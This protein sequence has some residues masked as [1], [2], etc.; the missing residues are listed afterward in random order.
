MKR[1]MR[2]SGVDWIGEIPQD[3]AVKKLSYLFAEIGSGTTPSSTNPAFYDGDI[4]WV[5]TGDLND[6]LLFE[7]SKKIT[8]D[9][10]SE[11]STLKIY[12]ENALIIAMYGATIGKTAITKMKCTVN[13]ACC[14]LAKAINVDIRYVHFWFLQNKNNIIS[15]SYGGGQPNISQD[16]IRTLKIQVPPFEE[17]KTIADYLDKKCAEI[18]AVINSKQEQNKLLKEQ[19]QSIIYE[20]VTK[21]LDKNAPMKDSGVEWIGEIPQ[22]WSVRRLK[23]CVS[24][25][26]EKVL[27]E[28]NQE[29]LLYLGLEHIEQQTGKIEKNYLPIYDFEGDTIKFKSGDVL[30]GKLRPYLAKCYLAQD[31]GKCSS[32]FL[33]LTPNDCFENKYVAYGMLSKGF[34]D[35]VDSSTFGVKM[36]RADWEFISKLEFPTPPRSVQKTITEYL[37]N[38]CAEL[39]RLIQANITTINELKE[40]R[41]SV[42]FEAVTG[43]MEIG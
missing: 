36:P 1:A 14:V 37:D 15:L 9:A 30:F 38:K 20:A 33:V 12:D 24:Q 19:R 35:Y 41:Q 32:E 25:R 31:S 11:Y 29:P 2:D 23:Y 10:L 4:E 42:I 5:N 21:G 17:Q 28:M 43:K 16:T 40:Y 18:D 6:G 13:Q 7:T 22:K 27:Y 26:M 34:I 8:Q 39:D 3:W